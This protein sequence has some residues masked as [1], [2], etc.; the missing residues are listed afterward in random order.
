M[1]IK[2]AK[3][4]DMVSYLS[5]AGIEPA[6]IKGENYWY[7][8]PLR[9]ERTP[10]FKVNRRLNKWFDFG[11]GR[12]GG[13][14]EFMQEVNNIKIPEILQK[15][16]ELNLPTTQLNQ[17]PSRS[18]GI[19]IVSTK[20]ISS[21]A[22]IRYYQSRRISTEIA[23]QFLCEVD[24][25]NNNKSYYALGFKN[26]AGGYELRSTYFKGSSHPKVPTLIKN[27]AATLAVFEGVF[28]LLSYCT[29][30]QHQPV[31]PRDFLVLNSVSFLNSN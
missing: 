3:E 15:L 2:E 5:A 12:G 19:E 20:L 10:S 21:P 4:I 1:T 8:S 7:H 24:Y 6:K 23:N 13:L 29:I 27:Q 25:R 14:I 31:A 11:E 18:T 26:D 16:N 28:D 17:L 22:L 30:C 9:K